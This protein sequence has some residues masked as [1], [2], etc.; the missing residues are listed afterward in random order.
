[1]LREPPD[2]VVHRLVAGRRQRLAVAALQHQPARAGIVDVAALD[3][4]A[5]AAGDPNAKLAVLRTWHASIR[6]LRP[7]DTSMPLPRDAST[8]NPRSVTCDASFSE[9]SGAFNVDSTIRAPVIS[10]GGQK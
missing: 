9:T 10:A 1:M 2:V 4:M 8:M 7:P 3:A 5:V 6:L